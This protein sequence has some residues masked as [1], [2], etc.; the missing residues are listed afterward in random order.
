MKKVA[1]ACLFVFAL[2]AVGSAQVQIQQPFSIYVS[3]AVSIPTAPSAFK[4]TYKAGI[5]G[6]AGVGYSVAP[7]FQIVGKVEYHSFGLDA[8]KTALS[9]SVPDLSGGTEKIM[10]FGAD[11]R[12]SLGVPMAPV[13]PF[14]LGGVGMAR[15]SFSDFTTSDPLAQAVLDPLNAAS[16]SATKVYYN[17]GGGVQ[18]KSGP[19]W[20]LFAQIRYVS[21]ATDGQASTFIPVSLGIKF[22]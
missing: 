13:K 3:G 12:F 9:L 1:L 10:L 6:G 7:N 2:A 4:D 15:I 14:L 17:V 19:M 21:V 16:T 5:H 18:L 22:F 11:G 20:S 8:A